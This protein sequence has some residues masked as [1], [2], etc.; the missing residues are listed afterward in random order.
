MRAR[1][2]TPSVAGQCYHDTLTEG[3]PACFLPFVPLH[4]LAGKTKS[5]SGR[6]VAMMEEHGS[7]RRDKYLAKARRNATPAQRKALRGVS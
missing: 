4:W 7:Y 1:K 6:L 3:L 5:D 2:G